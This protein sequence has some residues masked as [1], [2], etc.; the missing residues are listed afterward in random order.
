[1]RIIRF[2]QL[3]I[4]PWKNAGGITREIAARRV[5]EN[6][7]W[8]LSLAEVARDGPFSNFANLSRIL[9]VIKGNG[10]RLIHAGGTIQAR[11]NEPVQFD[12]ALAIRSELVD[13]PITD[14]NVIY[15]SELFQAEVAIRY[16]SFDQMPSDTVAIIGL[17]GITTIDG[18]HVLQIGDTAIIKN[19]AAQVNIAGK[20]SALA[21]SLNI[22][23][24]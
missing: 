14:L 11:L 10:M 9:T 4:Q 15:N 20:S 24:Q 17:A 12:G 7:V 6:I 18:R 16:E 3:Q 21:V 22:R 2:H 8:R 13:G 19:E 1:M 23:N 5:D